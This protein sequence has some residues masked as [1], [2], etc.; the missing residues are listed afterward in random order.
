[1]S[2]ESLKCALPAQKA[3]VSG[4][5]KKNHSQQVREV[6]LTLCSFEAPLGVLHKGIGMSAQER[7]LYVDVIQRRAIKMILSQEERMREL[8]LVSLENGRDFIGV[9][10]GR[11]YSILPLVEWSL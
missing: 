7:Y 3:N 6:I 4:M 2:L 11:P 5:H 10:L 9:S 8:G 1:M